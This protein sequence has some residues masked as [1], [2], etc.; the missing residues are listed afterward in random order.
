MASLRTCHEVDK[1][2]P[3]TLLLTH[4]QL[5]IAMNRSTI[6]VVTLVLFSAFKVNAQSSYEREFQQLTEQR[7][8][9]AAAALAPIDRRYHELLGQLLKRATQANDLTTAV[10][11][12]AKL[13]ESNSGSTPEAQLRTSISRAKWKWTGAGANT[14][15]F[16]PEGEVTLSNSKATYKVTGG[17]EIVLTSETS[18]RTAT[19]TFNSTFTKFNGIDF[20]G[21]TKIEG[22]I[23]K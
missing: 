16:T 8:K 4:F 9:A 21:R 15:V 5:K 11:I 7:D 10:K 3:G 2:Y 13:D 17:R 22:E 19:I 14:F 6:L 1:H 23:E 20:D 18:K 12:Q